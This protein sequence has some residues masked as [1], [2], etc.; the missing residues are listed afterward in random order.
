MATS[1][2][3]IILS[4]LSSQFSIVSIKQALTEIPALNFQSLLHASRNRQ[5]Q[6]FYTQSKKKATT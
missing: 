6:L 2:N 3:D 1:A 5:L 4:E